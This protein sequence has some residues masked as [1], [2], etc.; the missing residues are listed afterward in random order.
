MSTYEA[1]GGVSESLKTLLENTI[2][3]PNSVPA[4]PTPFPVW[5]G[6][7]PKDDQLDGNPLLNLFLYRIT[8]SP[9]LK[10]QEIPR[11]TPQTSYG[12]PPL[13]LVLHYLLTP[14]GRLGGNGVAGTSP[15]EV[16]AH[17]V[18]GS[19]MRVLHD[20]PALTNGSTAAGHPVLDASLDTAYEKMKLR[21][22]P[23]S[24]EDVSKV[25]TALGRPYRLS[26]AY[27]VS[28]IQIE[29]RKPRSYPQLV[30]KPPPE[31]PRVRAVAERNPL[32][33]ELQGQRLPGPYAGVGDELVVR[34][35]DLAGD[36]PRVFFGDVEAPVTSARDDRLTVLVPDDPRLELGPQRLNVIRRVEF[37]SPPVL[38]VGARS[39][40]GVWMFVPRVDTVDY[41]PGGA[42]TPPW[43]KIKGK[44]LFD[45][46]LR[47]IAFIDD[48]LIAS[49]N[50]TKKDA[51][52]IR[53]AFPSPPSP[54]S[55]RVRVLVNDVEALAVPLVTVA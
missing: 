21:L 33:T 9:F 7:P 23:I 30:G 45:Q 17:Y 1:I 31:G 42:A 4:P 55:H 22:E 44:R 15:D 54:G 41:F 29:S 24:L 14:Y 47:C 35:E 25:W 27:E 32:I 16:L 13:S 37:D 52:E 6:I 19:A 43:V 12:H 18:L 46:T 5:V 34:G 51:D 2:E 48:V 53:V 50:W 36:S 28:V 38:R 8:E 49:A 20:N 11:P 26:A 39:N 40:T 10:N 3:L